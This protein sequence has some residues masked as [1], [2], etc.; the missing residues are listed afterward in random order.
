MLVP[1]LWCL[2]KWRNDILLIS[3]SVW[4]SLTGADT[5]PKT[6]RTGG[7]YRWHQ[8]RGAPQR[9]KLP[10][11]ALHA[12][13]KKRGASGWGKES[14]E[15]LGRYTQGRGSWTDAEAKRS[16]MGWPQNN[17]RHSSI[18]TP[19]LSW[20]NLS[21]E[22]TPHLSLNSLAESNPPFA[23]RSR[24][25]AALPRNAQPHGKQ[26]RP[27]AK[28]AQPLDLPRPPPLVPSSLSLPTD[29]ETSPRR[30]VTR[31]RRGRE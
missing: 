12:N 15:R 22:T 6:L 17:E 1:Q 14:V 13:K 3:P 27:L 10:L 31:N 5:I 24:P 20:S 28:N 2:S 8:K 16:W 26:S 30:M 11:S 23:R 25:H 29:A 9:Q 18:Y 19:P 21:P 7:A 4:E